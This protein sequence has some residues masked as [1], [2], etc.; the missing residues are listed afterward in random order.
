LES[1]SLL[2]EEEL[3]EEEDE[4]EELLSESESD[5]TFRLLLDFLLFLAAL[6][7]RKMCF[8]IFGTF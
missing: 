3:D 7:F 5:A 8:R 1:P 2:L 4:L 6:K